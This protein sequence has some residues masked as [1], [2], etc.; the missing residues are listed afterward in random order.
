MIMEQTQ[1]LA[2]LNSQPVECYRATPICMHGVQLSLEVG[3]PACGLGTCDLGTCRLTTCDL[4]H[5]LS[6]Q[7][8]GS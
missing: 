7:C 2:P 5:A 1:V 4:T 3:H 8:L 6:H